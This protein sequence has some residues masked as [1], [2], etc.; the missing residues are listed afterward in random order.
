VAAGLLNKERE[1]DIKELQKIDESN[2]NVLSVYIEDVKKKLSVLDELSN[3]IDLLVK[4][5]NSRFLHKQMSISKN[6]GFIFRTSGN[7]D[8]QPTALSS[9]EQHELVLLFEMLFKVIPN[10]L[11]LIDEPELS[12]HVVWQKEFLKDLQEIARIAGFDFLIATHSPQIIHDRWDI[13]V[14]LTGPTN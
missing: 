13:T 8:L 5:I 12:L 9:G 7:K 1:I 11:I 3:K 4:I 2:R 14:E 10:S 6:E